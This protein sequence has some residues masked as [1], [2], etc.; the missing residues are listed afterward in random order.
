MKELERKDSDRI[1]ILKQQQKKNTIVLQN[2]IIPKGN[3]LL[4]EYNIIDK[5]MVLAKTEPH[6]TDVTW[7][8]AKA[9]YLSKSNPIDIKN[10]IPI[11]KTKVIKKPNCIYISSLNIK[12]AFKVLDRDYKNY[13]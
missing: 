12:N 6:R 8:E 1:E 2:R 7:N 13:I 11:S 9:F 5:T 3:H 10:P 4:F